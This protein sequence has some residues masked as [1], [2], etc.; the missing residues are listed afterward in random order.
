MSLFQIQVYNLD[1]FLACWPD[2]LAQEDPYPN[3]WS[4]PANYS[5]TP[6]DPGGATMNGIIQSE[7]DLY[8][9][10]HGLP[11]QSV[12]N[13]TKPQGEAIYLNGYWLPN[14]P[15][16]SAGLDLCVFDTDV[17]MGPGQGTMILQHVLGIGVDGIWGPQTNAA[18]ADITNV[19]SVI[20]NYTMRRE[21]VYR[22]FGT[23]GEFGTDWIRRAQTIGSQA[24]A[25]AGAATVKLSP[26]KRTLKAPSWFAWHG[27]VVKARLNLNSE[28]TIATNAILNGLDGWVAKDIPDIANF[29]QQALAAMPAVAA[30]CANDAVSAIE[31]WRA[32]QPPG[33]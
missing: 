32:T 25:M 14:V 10:T 1:R 3:D 13:I 29:R 4:N 16:L 27:G 22:S 6:G 30:S 19:V 8:L 15:K 7:Y 17:N 12:R 11:I 21:S 26:P 2:V 5:N 20:D 24:A 31:A 28:I 9:Q 23:F 33:A 18:V